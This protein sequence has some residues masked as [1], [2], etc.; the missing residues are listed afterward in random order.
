MHLKQYFKNM[1]FIS[2]FNAAT[3][4]EHL[5]LEGTNK[6]HPVAPHRITPNLRPMS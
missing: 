2:W 6:D 5:K 1:K 4:L 3:V